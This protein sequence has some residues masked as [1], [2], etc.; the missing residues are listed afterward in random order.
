MRNL[1]G[2]FVKRNIDRDWLYQKYVVER[3][4]WDDFK[5]K[6]N[7]SSCLLKSRLGEFGISREKE[8][9]NKNKR[10]VLKANA[11]SFQKGHKVG[12]RFGRD[13]TSAG[14][15]HWNWKGGITSS[16]MKIRNSKKMKEWRESVF[17][18][19][20]YTCQACGQIGGK[21]HADHV[22]PFSLFPELIFDTLNGRTLCVDCH[23]NTDTY[24]SKVRNYDIVAKI[25]SGNGTDF[26]GQA[27]LNFS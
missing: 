4:S 3:L 14:D 2:Q 12:V 23:K 9:W 19:D 8:A 18:R 22:M 6:Y 1:K 27:G 15:K 17:E 16:V 24:L 7:I 10:G 11:T 20:N 13:K 25:I 21:L 5:E 26:Y